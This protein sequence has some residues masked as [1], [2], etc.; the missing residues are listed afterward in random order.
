MFVGGILFSYLCICSSI[1]GGFVVGLG[2]GGGGGEGGGAQIRTA[3]WQCLV[4]VK[5]LFLFLHSK[6]HV[7]VL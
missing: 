1:H 4:T 3:Y 7:F 2:C 5:K 6:K